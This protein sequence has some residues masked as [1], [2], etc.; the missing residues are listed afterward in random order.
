MWGRI[1]SQLLLFKSLKQKGH[2][3]RRT[4][5]NHE[6]QGFP[7]P[8]HPPR[9]R[10][11]PL[12]WRRGRDREDTGGDGWGSRPPWAE[13]PAAQ[14]A[15]SRWSSA[16]RPTVPQARRG[17]VAA[18]RAG[19]ASAAH[20]GA[21]RRQGP[22]G[23][24]RVAGPTSVGTASGPGEPLCEFP[25]RLLVVL[26]WRLGLRPRVLTDLCQWRDV[27]RGAASAVRTLFMVHQLIQMSLSALGGRRWEGGRSHSFRTR[28]TIHSFL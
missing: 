2:A 18:R 24:R 19:R 10:G 26:T 1:I 4:N 28:E 25:G 15:I 3:A 5:G 20:S 9:G 23:C 27:G 13:P 14:S 6:A 21:P 12:G 22:D 7:A 11:E 16:R 17:E 8:H